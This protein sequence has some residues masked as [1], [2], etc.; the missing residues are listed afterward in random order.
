MQL[1][2]LPVYLLLI[3]LTPVML[4]AHRSWGLVVPAAMAARHQVWSAVGGVQE[5]GA[6]WLKFDP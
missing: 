1:W 5:E 4:S 2:F 6:A 3:A